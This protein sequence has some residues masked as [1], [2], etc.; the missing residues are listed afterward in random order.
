MTFESQ[1]Q[2]QSQSQPYHGQTPT[3]LAQAGV[4][5]AKMALD[6]ATRTAQERSQEEA[7]EVERRKQE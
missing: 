4:K 7:R 6:K 1:W 3:Q 5:L 2:S